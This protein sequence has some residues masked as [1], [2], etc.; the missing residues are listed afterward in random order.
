[1][2][3]ASVLSLLLV[4]TV[5]S[6]QVS[7]LPSNS[8]ATQQQAVSIVSQEQADLAEAQME[9]LA[10]R[11][12]RP[13]LLEGTLTQADYKALGALF[14]T[15]TQE[16]D[17]RTLLNTVAERLDCVVQEEEGGFLLLRDYSKGTALPYITLEETERTAQSIADLLSP[18]D[19]STHFATFGTREGGR[20]AG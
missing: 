11:L 16:D 2:Q 20:G 10:A 18:F 1:M 12:H 8:A 9:S 6:A 5:A 19:A 15:A 14:A 7:A 3:T 17:A 13:V 4:P